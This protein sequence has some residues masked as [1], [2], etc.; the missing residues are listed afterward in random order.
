M[1]ATRYCPPVKEI[2]GRPF[3]RWLWNTGCFAAFDWAK[4]HPLALESDQLATG[5]PSANA[6]ESARSHNRNPAT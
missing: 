4:F 2:P 1:G 3:W 5:A 6:N